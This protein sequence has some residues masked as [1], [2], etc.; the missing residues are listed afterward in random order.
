HLVRRRTPGL[1]R[2]TP[3]RRS[4]GGP[5]RGAVPCRRSMHFAED[6][7]MAMRA[8]SDEGAQEAGSGSRAR[9]APAAPPP[10]HGGTP[11]VQASERNPAVS[12]SF[13]MN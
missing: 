5:P 12:S 1:D 10:P 7:A 2:M 4:G 6:G 3:R 9:R 11:P 8:S 13:R